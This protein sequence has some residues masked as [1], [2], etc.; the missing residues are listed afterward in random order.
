MGAYGAMGC[1]LVL[2]MSRNFIY[3]Y[4][5]LIHCPARFAVKYLAK[6]AI[7]VHFFPWPQL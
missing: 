2:P 5:V 3:I 6:T 7:D 4:A 1:V